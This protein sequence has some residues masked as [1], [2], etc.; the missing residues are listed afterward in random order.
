[1]YGHAIEECNEFKYL[2]SAI[3]LEDVARRAGQLRSSKNISS[4]IKVASYKLHTAP[5]HGNRD[6]GRI[7]ALE[8]DFIKRSVK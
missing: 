3:P 7:N 1:M 6:R 5:K 8:M 4:G 2:G